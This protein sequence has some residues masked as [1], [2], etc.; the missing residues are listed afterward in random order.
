[1]QDRI[2]FGTLCGC[3][4]IRMVFDVKVEYKFY[5]IFILDHRE[6]VDLIWTD[7]YVT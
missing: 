5:F 2:S 4:I 3:L 1:M 6:L 7:T